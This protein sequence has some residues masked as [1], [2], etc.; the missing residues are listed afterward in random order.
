MA[1]RV[2]AQVKTA[3]RKA[4]SQ[5]LEDRAGELA[6]DRELATK[7]KS[8]DAAYRSGPY[9]LL[10]KYKAPGT[11]AIVAWAAEQAKSYVKGKGRNAIPLVATS[12]MGQAAA[13]WCRG[14]GVSWVDL[15]GNADIKAPGLSI[16]VWGN[17]PVRG[18][19]GRPPNV[20]APRSS[21][22]ARVLLHHPGRDYSQRDL[23]K[24]AKLDEGF[25]SRVV[26]NMEED[27]LIIRGKNGAV[28]ATDPNH[29][30]DAWR[31][32]YEFRQNE[33]IEGYVAGRSGEEVLQQLS[34]ALAQGN[35]EHAATGLGAAWLYSEFAMFRLVT[36][37]LREAPSDDE[38]RSI[39]FRRDP[40]GANVW[41]VLPKDAGVFY[42]AGKVGSVPCVSPL[43]V[44]LDLKSHPERASEAAEELRKRRLAWSE[45][46]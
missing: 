11:P 8:C 12:H 25:V 17:K 42:E 35:H 24:S 6:E 18:K 5:L 28:R 37:Y 27:K 32:R 46:A 22:I 36:I 41:L 4:L 2:G 44:Y 45:N 30:L 43:Q 40:R 7:L 16:H 34:K 21:R 1:R 15:A 23:A 39:S 3:L 33:I 29:L 20:F 38:L 31:E 14:E 13:D 10:V 9:L 26:R 19:S